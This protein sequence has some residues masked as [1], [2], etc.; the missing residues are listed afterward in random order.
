MFKP[1]EP[2]IGEQLPFEGPI[3]DDGDAVL[4]TDNGVFAMFS[5]AGVFP[6]T[7]DEHDLAAWFDQFHNAQKNI[8]AEDVELFVYK[9]RGEAEPEVYPSP[10][11]PDDFPQELDDTYR[12][13]LFASTLY[14]NPQYLAVVVHAP[15]IAAQSISRFFS[16][17]A[18]PRAG[19]RSRHVRLNEICNLLQ[20]QLTNFGL[21]RLGYVDRGGILYDE[22]AEAL[23]F[24][25][26][27]IARQIGATTGRMGNAIFSEDVHFRRRHI[28]IEGAGDTTYAVIYTFKDYPASTAPWM[29]EPFD[30]A[31]YR[32]TLAQSF[33]FLSN[34]A[35]GSVLDR[36]QNK[37]LIAGDKANAQRDALI[38][39]HNPL[40]DRKFV[41]GDHSLVLLA[42]A[43]RRQ[44][45]SAVSNSAWR[46]FASCGI[47]AKRVSRNLQAAYLS[48]FPGNSQLR[49]RPSYVNSINFSAFAP[50]YN[51]PAGSE[52][53]HWH[54]PEIALFRTLAGTPYRFHWHV[55]DVGNT[56]ITGSTGSGKTTLV[57]FLIAMT[58]GRAR[59]IGLDHKRGWKRL[60]ER[61]NG[62]YA[63]LGEGEPHLAPLKAF[64]PTHANIEFLTE[65]I[66]GCI[67]GAL[68]EEESRRLALGLRTIMQLPPDQRCLAELRAFFDKSPEGAGARLEKWCW[69][70]G[71]LGWVIDAPHHTVSLTDLCCYDTTAL[72]D[73]P[74][75]RAP[76]LACVLHEIALA[77]DG[78]P[79]LIPCDEGWRVLADD[80]FRAIIEKQLRTIRSKNGAVCFVTQDAHDILN[81]GIANVLVQQCPSQIH[82][83]NPRG[84]R[85]DY[86]GGL[87]LTPGQYD[88]FHVL[89]SG[90]GL[91]LHVQGTK[92]VIAQLPMNGPRLSAFLPIL[93][94][95]EA[96]LRA[97]DI[98]EF[99]EAAD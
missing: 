1:P 44:E 96:D 11:H 5:V 61:L 41:L 37:M 27:G 17:D 29:L 67:G 47:T 23:A 31:S 43:D 35:A 79:L 57:A 42:F 33:R 70:D 53:G 69:P 72:L 64:Y 51:W 20:S 2:L 81:S 16:D 28:E 86:V 75:A 34:A 14:A 3:S 90:Q 6:D 21:R 62:D 25:G 93:S 30:V 4:T 91:F 10:D 97:I 39:A 66:R 56:L 45:V 87:H 49:P 89:Q 52:T 50:L 74:R 46:D 78:R 19:I 98:S 36:K 95:P 55:G 38:D 22:I 54:G 60:F 82:L 48:I 68:T 92:S 18:D 9:C 88:A 15:N 73:N 7:A 59:I 58:A 76:A 26:T 99:K 13:Q 85:E 40:L 12:E 84:T 32:C 94:A 83:A 77:L 65:L 80:T 8:Q 24:A 71:E 63:V